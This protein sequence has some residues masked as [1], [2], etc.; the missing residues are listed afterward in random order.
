MPKA[1]HLTVT[2]DN[3]L[4]GSLIEH[5]NEIKNNLCVFCQ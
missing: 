4:D 3:I 2:N 5:I 1:V